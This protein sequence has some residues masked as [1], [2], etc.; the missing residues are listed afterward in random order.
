MRKK[1]SW[2]YICYNISFS[3]HMIYLLYAHHCYQNLNKKEEQ[4]TLNISVNMPIYHLLW[5][6]IISH[7]FIVKTHI[8]TYINSELKR[9]K[10]KYCLKKYLTQM[11]NKRPESVSMWLQWFLDTITGKGQACIF[12]E[13]YY[14]GTKFQMSLLTTGFPHYIVLLRFQLTLFLCYIGTEEASS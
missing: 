5:F 9:W 2:S 6:N 4:N 12:R 3:L 14:K 7:T 8:H 10:L 11:I 1:G 13:I